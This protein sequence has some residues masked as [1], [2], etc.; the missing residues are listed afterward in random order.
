MCLLPRAELHSWSNSNGLFVDYWQHA[1][2][3]QQHLKER[4]LRCQWKDTT[5]FDISFF[6]PSRASSSTTQALCWRGVSWADLPIS[7]FCVKRKRHREK[8]KWKCMKKERADRKKAFPVQTCCS[9]SNLPLE[10]QRWPQGCT[11]MSWW[12]H[13]SVWCVSVCMC[14]YIQ[15]TSSF[16]I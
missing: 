8:V 2:T 14:A 9:N 7:I 1:G 11:M 5:R 16:S 12:V 13:G 3:C 6:F 10:D 15:C 4:Q